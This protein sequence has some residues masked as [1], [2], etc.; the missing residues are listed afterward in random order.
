[1]SKQTFPFF[2]GQ[3]GL[4]VEDFKITGASVGATAG[5]AGLDGRGKNF[6]T[7]SKS[8]NT[9]TI[10]FNVA[11]PEA[12]YVFFTVLTSNGAVEAPVITATGITFT[13]QERDDNTA[14]LND[15]DILVHVRGY[16]TTSYM[17]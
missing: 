16:N 12:P 10:V 3:P 5:T 2:A 14:G 15:C 11:Y 13:T 4:K 8:T 7:I 17:S 9:V 6:C 1:M